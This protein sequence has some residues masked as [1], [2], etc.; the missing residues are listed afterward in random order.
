MLAAD[1]M[2]AAGTPCVIRPVGAYMAAMGPN[3]GALL[4]AWLDSWAVVD[5]REHDAMQVDARHA[6]H[7]AR[8]IN[9][10]TP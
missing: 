3:V 7:I 6:L 2:R 8:A 10:R 9:A 1:G 5:I 4:A